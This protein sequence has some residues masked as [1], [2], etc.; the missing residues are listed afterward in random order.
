MARY[1][2]GVL[3]SPDPRFTALLEFCDSRPDLMADPAVELVKK[4]FEVAPA[5]L[6]EHG[7]VN[8]AAPTI[9]TTSDGPPYRRR[10]LI[11]TSTLPPVRG[12]TRTMLTRVLTISQGVCCIITV[13]PSSSITL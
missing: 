5:V 4:T 6:K 10:T 8:T 1:G 3:R 2:H 9:H 11:P 12:T 7:K 13:L